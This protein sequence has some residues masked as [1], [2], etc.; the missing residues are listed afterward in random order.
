LT[1]KEP[2]PEPRGLF[3]AVFRSSA[4]AM[5]ITR[6]SDGIHLEANDAYLR[7][8][9][10]TL[11]EVVGH[12]ASELNWAD[13]ADPERMGRDLRA[14]GKTGPTRATLLNAQGEPR[15]G[16]YSSLVIDFHGEKAV[17]TSIADL[18]D[19]RDAEQALLQQQEKLQVLSDNLPGFVWTTDLN[20]T[21][22]SSAGAG[23][24]G[25]AM[26]PADFVGQDLRQLLGDTPEHLEV[27]EDVLKSGASTR[28]EADWYGRTWEVHLVPLRVDGEIVGI[29]GAAIDITHRRETEEALKRTVAELQAAHGVRRKLLSKLVAVQEHERQVIASEIHDDSLQK[30]A[31]V[32]LRLDVLRRKLADPED[33]EEARRLTELV[34]KTIDRLRHLM[35]ELWPP[36]LERNG[37]EAAVRTEL[38]S[39]Q[40]ESDVKVSFDNRYEGVLQI[41]LATV[42]YRI[43]REALLNARRHSRAAHINVSLEDLN[44]GLLVKI[45][46]DGVGIPPEVVAN[47]KPGHLGIS[48][49]RERADLAAGWLKIH[50]PVEATGKGTEIEFWIPVEP[51]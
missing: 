24:P 21:V 35:F 33:A 41:D 45:C 6:I 11:E 18:T 27:M 48:A 30:M 15:Y 26:T 10:L 39:V 13:K 38:V 8:S 46:D 25:I 29:N 32:G 50:S 47:T 51:V 43:I 34:N 49:M 1:E 42:A 40:G 2:T 7:M 36:T 14:V 44:G 23:S 22:T 20:M 37:L 16:S 5:I 28:R 3:D 17:L 19:L 4:D 31:A 9:G 12:N